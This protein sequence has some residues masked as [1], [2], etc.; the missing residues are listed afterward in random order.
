[1]NNREWT[2]LIKLIKHVTE[3]A[4]KKNTKDNKP[5]K[6]WLEFNEKLSR[7]EI[8]LKHCQTSMAFA[9]VEGSLIRAV[10]EGNAI[11][12]IIIIFYY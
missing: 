11:Q 10:K 12:I 4:I 7:F 2:K 1:M 9:F 3:K 6:L 5:V 8:Q